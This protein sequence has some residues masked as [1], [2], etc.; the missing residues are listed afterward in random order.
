MRGIQLINRQFIIHVIQSAKITAMQIHLH[1]SYIDDVN[2]ITYLDFIN[3][4][5]H[6]ATKIIR[7][8]ITF[9]AFLSHK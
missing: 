9:I 5:F 4:I 2:A 8:Q 6:S 3:N 7:Q 1:Y